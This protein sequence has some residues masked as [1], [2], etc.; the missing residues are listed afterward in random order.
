MERRVSLTTHF[1]IK[2]TKLLKNGEAPIYARLSINRTK[3]EM[4]IN[5]SV[6][7]DLWH[8]DHGLVLGNSKEAKQLNL[9]MKTLEFQLHEHVRLLR[10]E[11]NDITAKA[12]RNSFQGLEEE[13]KTILGIFQEHNDDIKERRGIDFSHETWQKYEACR[14]HLHAYIVK[15]YNEQDLALTDIDHNFIHYFESFLKTERGN[16]HNTATKFLT[17]F[18]KIIRIALA[19]GWLKNDPFSKYKMTLKK[20]DRGFLTDNELQAII[21]L[22]LKIDRLSTVRD[23]FLFSCFTGLAYSDLKKLT[24]DDIVIGTNGKKWIKIKR[25]KTEVLS[26]IPI[27]PVVQTIIDRY[28]NHPYC[29]EKDV[30]L[31]VYSNQKMNGY[32]KEIAELSRIKKN[33]TTH[34]ARH[35]FAT[36]VTLNNDVPIE[37]VSKMLGHSSINMTKVYA[38]LLDKKVGDDMEKLH[39]KYK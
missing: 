28:Q 38:R 15:R 4:A 5:R 19:N 3:I 11:G 29:I 12:V 32:L 31:P 16:N 35:T 30:L 23:C 21:D 33:L 27:L 22:D 25:K 9:S 8:M 6:N 1:Y 36:T 10:E 34:L 37:S 24:E 20:V 14:R 39:E 17:N 2:R 26:K 7:P 13:K 18:K